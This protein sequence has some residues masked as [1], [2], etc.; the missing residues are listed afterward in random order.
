[1]FRLTLFAVLLFTLAI[2]SPAAFGTCVAPENLTEV[3]WDSV[4]N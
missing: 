4:S 3:Q 1:M 2:R